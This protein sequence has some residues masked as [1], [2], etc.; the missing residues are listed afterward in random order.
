MSARNI[1][2]TWCTE[3]HMTYDE[4]LARD[5]AE[6]RRELA[7]RGLLIFKGL[8]PE[9]GDA[10]FSRLGEKFGTLWDPAQYHRG[11]ITDP[12][13]SKDEE[14]PVSYFTTNNNRW[15]STYMKYHADMAHIGEKSFPARALYMVRTA[16]DRSGKTYWLNLEH[17]WAQFTEEEKARYDGITVTQHFLYDPGTRLEDFPFLKTNPYT[18]KVSPR[19]NCYGSMHKTWIHHVSDKNGEKITKFV[20]FMEEVYKLCESKTDTLY[21]HDWDNGDILIYD[22]WFSVHRR[23]EV[24]LQPG[25]PVRLLKRLTFNI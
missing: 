17:A 19:L 24:T 7:E 20:D 2:D 13:L 8:S 3:Y 6:W 11:S 1:F 18:G 14:N 15:A 21:C 10:K 5:S 25:E 9:L 12:T 16:N 4:I 22:N 23:D